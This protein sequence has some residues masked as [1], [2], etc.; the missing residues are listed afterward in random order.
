MITTFYPPYHFG[1]D[2]V[3]VRQLSNEL[4]QRGHHVEVVHCVDSY[5]L[6]APREPAVP[7]QNHPNVAVHGL[8]SRFGFLSPLATQQ[9]GIPFFKSNRIREILK[10]GFD[11]IHYHNISL[12]GGPKILEYGEG[13]KLY[14][15]HDYWLVCPTHILFK[16]NRSLCKRPH[17]LFCSLVHKRPPQWWRYS[18]L[19]KEAIKHVDRFI[20]LNHFSEE[21]HRRRGFHL[22]TAYLPNFIP[23]PDAA[24][25]SV[26]PPVPNEAGGPPY[27]LF[28]GRLERLKGLHQLIRVFHRYRKA[29]LLIAGAGSFEPRLRQLAGDRANIR[30]LGYLS[31]GPLQALYRAA[32]A[33]IVPSLCY[34]MFP[35]VILEAFRQQTPVVLENL[36][37]MPELLQESGGGY[38]YRTEEELIAAMD[39]LLEDPSS[40][41]E[42][43]R[44][45][46]EAFRRNW[47]TEV[48]VKQYLQLIREIAT[49]RC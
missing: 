4:A 2:G 23:S 19:L 30:F 7:S 17:C 32:T 45:G 31:E 24:A 5:R 38:L 27:F 8:K 18:G 13:V 40:R 47:T 44:R 49:G 11:V 37:G 10:K 36:G 25:S 39:K 22:P 33:V 46:Y 34:E 12:V 1:G 6:L 43:G 3:F 26:S 14:T 41:N 48:H 15:L 9:T 29:R 21:M 35:L 16:F 42:L 28:V 20:V